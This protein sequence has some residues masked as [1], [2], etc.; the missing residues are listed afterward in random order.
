MLKLFNTLTRKK[1][2]FKPLKKNH[3][4]LYTCGPT[5][6]DF[7]HIGNFRTYVWQDILKRWLMYKGLKVKHVMNLTDVDD[8]TIKGSRKEGTSLKKFTTRYSKEFFADMKAL[9][10]LPADI[11][12]KAT[13]HIDEMVEM[14]KTLLKKGFAYKTNDG[15]YFDISKFKDYGKLSKLKMKDLKAG[16]RVRN[17]LYTKEEAQDFA[18]W[19]FWDEE[20]DDV[21]WEPIIEISVSETEY[22]K[23][24]KSAIK[25][26]DVEFLKLNKIR[27]G[28]K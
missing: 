4:G 19:K 17:D 18:L 2:S 28:K 1:E 23:L 27:V 9:N 25:N 20:D 5:V 13:E 24:I 10:I 22:K 3:V 11:F 8:K 12:P 16:A 21:F 7:A 6:Y 14:I 15:I 26:N